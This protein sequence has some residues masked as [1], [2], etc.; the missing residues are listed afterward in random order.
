MSIHM[1]IAA[2]CEGRIGAFEGHICCRDYTCC[3]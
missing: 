1:V 2:E 3:P